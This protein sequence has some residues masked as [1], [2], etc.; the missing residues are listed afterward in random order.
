MTVYAASFSNVSVTA[1]QDFFEITAPTTGIVIIH[2]C[3]ISQTSDVGDA[4]EEGLLILL[5]RGQTTSGSGG[6]T[7]TPAAGGAMEN[8]GPA[9]P[10]ASGGVVEANNTTKASAGTITTLHAEAWNVRSVFDFLPVPEMRPVLSPGQRA[11]FELATTPAD[12]LSVSGVLQFEWLG[13]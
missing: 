13:G 5:K 6:T 4:A 3:I 10:T 12:A 9:Y 1:Q 11:T 2:R 8:A 7:V